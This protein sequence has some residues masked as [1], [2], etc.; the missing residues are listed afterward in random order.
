MRKRFDKF[1]MGPSMIGWIAI[2]IAV[3]VVV[4]FGYMQLKGAGFGAIDELKNLFRV[5]G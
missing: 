1:G 4:L 5:R 3:A 2:G